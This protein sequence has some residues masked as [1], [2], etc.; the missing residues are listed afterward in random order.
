MLPSPDSTV[1]GA[2]FRYL[3]WV[4]LSLAFVVLTLI[5]AAQFVPSLRSLSQEGGLIEILSV[6]SW[7]VTIAFSVG[8]AFRWQTLADRLLALWLGCLALLAGLRELDSHHA[9][10]P[11]HLG[12]YGVRFRI[13]WW[14]DGNVNPALKVGWLA[15]FIALL[16]VLI[17]P[18]WKLRLP[19]WSMARRG[20][21]MF[22]ILILAFFFC[23]MG[24]FIDDQLRRTTFI[25]KD[26]RH[27][28][29]ETSEMLGAMA[30]AVSTWLGWAFPLAAQVRSANLVAKEEWS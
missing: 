7:G 11:D 13:S 23:G 30:F 26:L 24:G 18:P 2:D 10:S 17:Y 25:P 28:T 8:A 21:A 4:A 22:G 20:N 5:I 15:V 3:R 27:L 12:A 1:P 16:A 14:L 9:L 19:V 29:E 6:I